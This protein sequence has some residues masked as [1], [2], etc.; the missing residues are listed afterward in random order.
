MHCAR[1]WVVPTATVVQRPGNNT[2]TPLWTSDE[3]GVAVTHWVCDTAGV[4]VLLL[5]NA[6]LQQQQQQH[7]GAECCSNL[8]TVHRVRV[9]MHA[10]QRKQGN[11]NPFSHCTRLANM[12]SNHTT[13][14]PLP[15]TCVGTLSTAAVWSASTRA[16]T[17]RLQQQQRI[18]SVG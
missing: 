1:P 5:C 18:H 15:C 13:A 4:E 3:D 7:R 11:R 2:P 8:P 9:H 10:M 17:T 14:V 12:Q 6:S 16:V